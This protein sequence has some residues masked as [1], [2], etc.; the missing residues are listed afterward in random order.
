MSLRSRIATLWKALTRAE[1]FHREMTDE[2]SF[3]IEQRA[4]DL[5]RSGGS[6]EDALRRARI[7]LGGIPAQTETMRASWGTRGW[8]DLYADIRYALRSFARAPGLTAIAVI[9]LALGIGANTVIFS[10]TKHILL[11]RLTAYKPEELRLLAWI[12]PRKSAVHSSWGMSTRTPDG[13]RLSTSF[14]YPAYQQLRRQNR[15]F[16]DVFAFKEFPRLTATIDAQS[17]AVSAQLVSGNFYRTL[18]VQTVLGR[19]ILDS[20]DGAPGSGAVAVISDE[21]WTRRFGLA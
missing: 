10:V 6:R 21:F 8:D 11:D 13:K 12:S 1:Q 15:V 20:D 7:E 3:H 5:M 9:S 17:E 14:T 16:D 19:P 4:N 18:G 2:L